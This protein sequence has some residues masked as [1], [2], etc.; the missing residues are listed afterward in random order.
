MC[1]LPCFLPTQHP[2]NHFRFFLCAPCSLLLDVDHISYFQ[3]EAHPCSSSRRP[4]GSR[5]STT[6]PTHSLLRF[7]SGTTQVTRQLAPPYRSKSRKLH[8]T[9]HPSRIHRL[10]RQRRALPE[11][12]LQPGERQQK[13]THFQPKTK[14]VLKCVPYSAVLI[15]Q[16]RRGCLAPSDMFSSRPRSF[17][18]LLG[19]DQA[20]QVEVA[21]P[22]ILRICSTGLWDI[23]PSAR[24]YSNESSSES[25]LSSSS[26]A[27]MPPP[28]MTEAM[29]GTD[30]LGAGGA[31]MSA[32][33]ASG[34]EFI[35]SLG[36]CLSETSS[37]R[38]L[39]LRFL[40]EDSGRFH[41]LVAG[42]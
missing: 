28:L 29:D 17:P 12:S 32:V 37:V 21:A 9:I 42:S 14:P 8:Q 2:I 36:R 24:L 20:L 16:R 33:R 22:Y 41:C 15:S 26:A 23:V 25:S 34:D 13:Q 4:V 19:I 10:A 3:C 35:S 27:S 1:F 40:A 39:M 7:A 5:L 18:L 31:G 30:G 11:M 6:I 38:G